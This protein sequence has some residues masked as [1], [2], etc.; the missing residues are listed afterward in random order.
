M[1]ALRTVPDM[2]RNTW[3]DLTWESE[4]I[5]EQGMDH[6]VVILRGLRSAEGE[7]QDMVPDSVVVR[8]PHQAEYRAQAALES[9]IIAQLFRNSTA[10]VPETVRQAYA[11]GTFGTPNPV[12]LSL[13]TEVAGEPLTADVWAR[14][15]DSQR[16][17]VIEQL[18][19]MFARMHTMDPDLL[20]LVNVEP[21]W[22]DG[23]A[24]S[25]LNMNPRALPGKFELMKTR[26]PEFLTGN[27]SEQELAAV[28]RNFAQIEE[29]LARPSQQR[30]LT[31][32]DLHDQHV[33]WTA[34]GGVGVIDFSDM[35][36]GDPA[37]DYMHLDLIDAEL[38]SLVL[39]A[40]EKA[41]ARRLQELPDQLQHR[42][43]AL[44][45]KLYELDNILERAAIYKQW[46]NIFLLIDHFRTGRSERVSL[47]PGA[48]HGV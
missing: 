39:S 38:P 5:P 22:T 31:H 7:L 6:A 48:D 16:E 26:V 30:C 32:G 20:P 36:V 18:G 14:M 46:D 27:I 13:Q 17:R 29:L 8:V 15:T 11:R 9:S 37:V 21:W 43:G 40:A 4:E 24:T 23:E 44:R 33:L 34:E 3:R 25:T 10:R 47:D 41:H 2:V 12:M 35:T 19:T 42:T 1:V 28:E 45:E